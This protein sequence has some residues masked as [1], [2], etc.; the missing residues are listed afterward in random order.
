[1]RLDGFIALI[2][3]IILTLAY[4]YMLFKNAF[5]FIKQ[6]HTISGLKER[7]DLVSTEAEVINVELHDLS[8]HKKDLNKMYVMR[9]KYQTEKSARGIE[10]SEL[11]FAKEPVERAGQSITVLYSRDD[12][13]KIMMPDNRESAGAAAMFIKLAVSVAIAFGIIFAVFYCLCIYGFPND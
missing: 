6:M 8:G 3:S 5:P 7:G 10:H 11:I 12:P 9:V 2:L 1:M 4:A 13:S